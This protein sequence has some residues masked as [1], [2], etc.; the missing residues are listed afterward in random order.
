MASLDFETGPLFF[1]SVAFDDTE[2]DL[3]IYGILLKKH[4]TRIQMRLCN[5]GTDAAGFEAV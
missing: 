4:L 1:Q 5:R 2:Q 3:P